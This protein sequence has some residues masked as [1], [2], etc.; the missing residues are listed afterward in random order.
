MP[1]PPPAAPVAPCL[2]LRG[3][4]RR[5]SSRADALRLRTALRH[6][7]LLHIWAAPLAEA[8]GSV[9]LQHAAL[10]SDEPHVLD[11]ISRASL[12]ERRSM[13]SSSMRKSRASATRKSTHKDSP[14]SPPPAPRSQHSQRQAGGLV[15]KA[16]VTW[17]DD[18]GGAVALPPPAATPVV[19]LAQART[20]TRGGSRGMRRGSSVRSIDRRML[21]KSVSQQLIVGVLHAPS[22]R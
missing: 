11:N 7:H 10:S 13:R 21:E 18:G 14:S 12:D 9:E 5:V 15:R 1:L 6:R 3:G 22:K 8:R 19:A 17:R 4:R 2:R 16:S 20:L